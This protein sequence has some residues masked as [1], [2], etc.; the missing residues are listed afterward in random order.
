MNYGVDSTNELVALVRLAKD[1][2]RPALLNRIARIAKHLGVSRERMELICK[3]VHH[4]TW[5]PTRKVDCPYAREVKDAN[6]IVTG[7]EQTAT[8]IRVQQY[9]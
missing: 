5:S 8:S 3:A 1:S 6:G 4:E 2:P 9:C 7:Y